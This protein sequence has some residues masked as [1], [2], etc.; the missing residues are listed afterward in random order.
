MKLQKFTIST[1]HNQNVEVCH[2]LRPQAV[3]R[4]LE[5]VGNPSETGGGELFGGAR[6][7]PGGHIVL[8]DGREWLFLEHD[9]RL[10]AVSGGHT[11]QLPEAPGCPSAI[12]STADRYLVMM[13][14]EA[15]PMWLR[16]NAG[17]EWCWESS[18]TVPEPM[19]IVRRDEAVISTTVGGMKLKGSYT[20]RSVSL[21]EED[22]T[23]VGRMMG[24]AY[25]V[26]SHEAAVR[27]VYFQPVVARYCLIG[28]DGSIV[29][30]SAPVLLTPTAG[31]QLL[32][33]S[34]TLSGSDFS[35]LSEEKLT[36]TAFSLSVR[37]CGV[38]SDSWKKVVKCVRLLVSPQIHPYDGTALTTCRF[39]AFT[40][41][42]GS[43]RV[44]LPGVG[45]EAT[46]AAFGSRMRAC[47]EAVLANHETALAPCA[48]ARFDS[49]AGSPVGFE[50]PSVGVWGDVSSEINHLHKFSTLVTG[51]ADTAAETIAAL[52]APHQLCG[53]YAIGGGDT[54]LHTV[55]SVKRF[56]GWLPPE[57]AIVT[58]DASTDAGESVPV[59][60]KVT[61]SDGSSCVRSAVVSGFTI[62]ALSPLLTYPAADAV[63]LELF[64]G[65][66]YL[67]AGLRPDPSGRFAY[68]LSETAS[69]VE[70][71][72]D[73]PAF[74]LPAA[75]P[76]HR[77]FPGLAVIASV[78]SPLTPQ[79]VVQ[80][81]EPDPVAVRQS[82]SSVGGWDSGSARFYLF[83]RE[84]IQ[85][86][87]AN[88]ARARL[89]ARTLDS[90]PVV[91]AAAVTPLPDGA[92]AVLAGEDL[93]K[94]SGQKVT[95][96][97][98]FVGAESLGWNPLR[99]ELLCFH[100]PGSPCPGNFLHAEGR[101]VIPLSP[102]AS[103]FDAKGRL[104]FTRSCPLVT[105]V[106]S[107]GS[108][109]W[110]INADGCL[111]DFCD[112]RGDEAVEVIYRSAV[113]LPSPSV[114][115]RCVE[116]PLTGEIEEGA[117]EIRGHNG[118]GLAWSDMI[119]SI[120]PVGRVGCLPP[121]E[122]LTPPRSCL[123]LSMRLKCKKLTLNQR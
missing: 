49:A 57:F 100:S 28:Y 11:Q 107:D 67:S 40:A 86:L 99:G 15:A 119:S 68:W 31:P 4:G 23:T 6:L 109:L 105:S 104:L 77:R 110:G 33:A 12:V 118:G 35:T 56:G 52:S 58:D 30:A 55:V 116:I 29:Y 81:T 117:I 25:K 21:T 91:G 2:N 93:V 123:Q 102:N 121:I 85:M 97:S 106:L 94:I 62:G 66:S 82:S 17:G 36:V 1:L 76:V 16:I 63:R 32:S 27:R 112:E 92:F 88:S 95:H 37:P 113:G 45:D 101:G 7:L 26:V 114:S 79:A 84:G 72:V 38:L 61:F 122:V 59:A 78:T 51:A 65:R 75:S 111:Y 14:E 69:P 115:R 54:I 70:M 9:G 24:D 8:P 47:V 3:G 89:T 13:G 18:E 73:R 39:G 108:G 90:R 44:N 34:F 96:L 120:S 98:S 48:T 50:R 103:V 74:I 80:T 42:A 71:T 41:T 43:L 83:G 46:P 5:S 10:I 22:L 53:A 60:V 64:C 20:S 87:T 19:A